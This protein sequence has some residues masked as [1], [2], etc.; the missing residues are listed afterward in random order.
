VT[1]QYTN[2]NT[3]TGSVNPFQTIE[4]KDVGITL[5]L[6]SQIGEGGTIRMTVY[7]E[8]SSL[9]AD[10]T[11][12]TD[13]SSI[14]TTVVVDDGQT[15]VLGG[16][17]KD[18]YGDS[19]N[20]VPLLGDIPVLGNLF[21]NDSRKRTKSNLMLFLRPMVIRSQTD[22]DRLSVNRYEAIRALQ[23]GSQPAE[24]TVLPVDGAPVVPPV[25]V[26]AAVPQVPSTQTP[27][28][29]APVPAAPGAANADVPAAK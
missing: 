10:N 12:I 15:M 9:R 13:K 6:K 3:S 29:Q 26:S 14:E 4:R 8:S 28:A 1:G 18:E 17:L 25:G 22:L 11:S 5:K 20:K 24:R 16:L 27:A 7:Q 21:R 23:Q 2:A 19:E